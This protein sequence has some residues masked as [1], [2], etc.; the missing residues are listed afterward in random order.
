VPYL[1]GFLRHRRPFLLRR[2][3]QFGRDPTHRSLWVDREGGP[4]REAT[5]RDLIKRYTRKRFGTA[6]WPHLSGTDC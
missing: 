5:L 4:M 1:E 6:I 3:S 2:A